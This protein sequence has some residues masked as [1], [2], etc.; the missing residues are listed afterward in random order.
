MNP[1]D[2]HTLI[3]APVNIVTLNDKREF[4]DVIQEDNLDTR[5][6]WIIRMGPV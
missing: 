3:P 5:I 2:V 6:E 1:Q 4:I